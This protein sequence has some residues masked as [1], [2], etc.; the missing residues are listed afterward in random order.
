MKKNGVFESKIFK[1]TIGVI[2]ICLII[3]LVFYLIF[4]L[5]H[6][7]QANSSASQG[8]SVEAKEYSV[9]DT[10]TAMNDAEDSMM[11]VYYT[12]L[13]GSTV[14]L[15]NDKVMHF[16]VDGT[17]TGY[18]D[19]NNIDVSNYSYEVIS[20]DD[21]SQYVANVNIYNE[22]KTS[23]VQYKLCFDENSDMQLYYPD[24]VQTFKLEF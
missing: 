15:G 21:E 8:V 14:N 9:N 13:Q 11:N 3:G 22:D 16:E 7:S 2:N 19:D 18:F 6:K 23:V 5:V 17:F 20:E 24:A 1:I 12:L 4:A 10:E